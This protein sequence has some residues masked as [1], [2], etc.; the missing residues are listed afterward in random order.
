MIVG[1]VTFQT[2]QY[3]ESILSRI[4]IAKLRDHAFEVQNMGFF[5][6]KFQIEG[7]R[8]WQLRSQPIQARSDQSG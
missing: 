4:V 6:S 1:S 7:Y 2:S 5:L 8:I 3:A